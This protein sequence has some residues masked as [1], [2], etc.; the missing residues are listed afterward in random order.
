MESS[1]LISIIGAFGVG[2]MVAWAV[3]QRR[4]RQQSEE[5]LSQFAGYVKADLYQELKSE[6]SQKQTEILE[7]ATEVSRQEEVIGNQRQRMQEDEQRLA[8][9]QR[10]FK[11][12]FQNLANR[13]FEEKSK[14]MTQANAEK[15]EAII[16]PFDQKIQDFG[17]RVEETYLKGTQE[18]STLKEQLR[19]LMAVNNQLSQ[20]AIKL[21]DALKGDA[22]FQGSWG[23]IQ[24]KRL[25][26]KAGLEEGVHFSSQDSMQANDGSRYRTDFI[27]HLPEGKHLILDSKVSM[28]AFE[29][30]FN[31]DTEEE[32]QKALNRHLISVKNHIK[33]LSE[34]NYPALNGINPP[35]YVLMF[36][37]L[38]P[39]FIAAVQADPELY[40]NALEKNIAI[41][42]ASTL[43]ATLRTI[44]F[45]WKSD[46][47]TRNVIEIAKEAGSLYDKFVGFLENM[48]DLG[49]RLEA[50]Q[51]EYNGAMNKLKT[52]PRAG[53][54][55]IGKVE[56]LRELGAKTSKR[57]PEEM[58]E[59]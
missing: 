34:K 4:V 54:T 25:L 17:K 23:E 52:S 53:S 47:Q 45:I 36:M 32:R 28:V 19:Q 13:I 3:Y 29:Q 8:G 12:E 35:D 5:R 24:L 27:I 43:M 40:E 20:D 57:I 50:A 44:A 22:Q 51:K 56:K 37:P 26:E 31:A 16:K 18:R 14:S 42:S 1:I 33:G 15:L 55:L 48:Q 46:N 2:Y 59:G 10:Q 39:A 6:L 41:V 7:L 30:Y 38:E 21:T 49:K 11:L 9:L 58:L